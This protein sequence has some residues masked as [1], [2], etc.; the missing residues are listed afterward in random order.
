MAVFFTAD[1]HFGHANIIALC[2][3]PFPDVEAMDQALV[4]EW[5][6]VVTP[7]DEVWVLGDVV[8]PKMKEPDRYLGRLN[9]RKRLVVGNHDHR[10]TRHSRCWDQ[11][12]DLTMETIAGRRFALC[13]YPLLEHPGAFQ[14]VIHLHGHTHGRLPNDAQRLDVG[15]DA[16][17]GWAPVPV[18]RV[19]ELVAAEAETPPL[20]RRLRDPQDP[21]GPALDAIEAD[22]P[23]DSD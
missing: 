2:R 11:V 10:A 9:G 6:A 1:L 19:L 3:R 16:V 12:T 14:K 17:P 20:Y 18:E 23:E 7:K 22:P 8:F 4:A 15:V 5:N 21:L 13:H